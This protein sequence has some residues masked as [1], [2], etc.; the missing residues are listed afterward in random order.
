MPQQLSAG[1]LIYRHSAGSLEVLLAHPGGPFFRGKDDGAWSIPKGLVE[2][3]EDPLAAAVREFREET[4]VGLPAPGGA[5]GGAGR[6]AGGAG[7]D[8]GTA[9]P[10]ARRS[11]GADAGPAAGYLD[12]GEI[13]QRGGKRVAAW[14]FEADLDPDTFESNSFEMEW[15]P[16]SGQRTWFP[17]VDRCSYFDPE[18][19]RRKINPRQAPFIDRLEAALS[20]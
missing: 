20:G 12:L 8:P 11:D 2:A 3:G 13:T 10:A 1:L 6:G 15:P 14:A 17:E 19:A 7:P 16:R 5:G 4:G 18:T 9:G